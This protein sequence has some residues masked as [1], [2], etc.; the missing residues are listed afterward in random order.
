MA[1]ITED[2]VSFETAKLLKEKG[3]DVPVK[4]YFSLNKDAIL[5]NLDKKYGAKK[6]WNAHEICISRPS[7]SI[8]LKWLREVHNILIGV[9][10]LNEN[11]KGNTDYSN[12]DRWWYFW[13]FTDTKGVYKEEL[14][15]DP[16]SN[17]YSTYE[18]AAE[19]AIKYCLENLI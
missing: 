2:F 18:E 11:N 17:E 13:E 4:N 8:A 15:P 1:T 5:H 9:N 16:L 7:Q 10:V 6:N 14:Q 3:F 19:A 12:P